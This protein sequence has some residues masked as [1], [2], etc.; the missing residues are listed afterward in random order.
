MLF[1]FGSFLEIR[2]VVHNHLLVRLFNAREPRGADCDVICWNTCIKVEPNSRT[3]R[4]H[5]FILEQFVHIATDRGPTCGK[6]KLI[7]T[8][9]VYA[10]CPITSPQGHK[11]R[12]TKPALFDLRG[13]SERQST[14]L[15]RGDKS[16]FAH[17]LQRMS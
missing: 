5:T 7:S 6:K 1:T 14:Q 16:L 10:M 9:F 4:P 3:T 8:C 12:G 11:K 15:L 2:Q 17:L 13:Q